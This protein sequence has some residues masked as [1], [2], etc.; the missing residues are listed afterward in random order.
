MLLLAN[1]SRNPQ[2]KW[3]SDCAKA[4]PGGGYLGFLYSMQLAGL[5]GKPPPNL[6]ASR[7]FRGT[8]IAVMNTNLLDG[9]NNIQIDFK[10]SPFGRQSH[11]YNSNNAFLL[12]INGQRAFISSGN[13]DLYGSEHHRKWMC[14][15]KS[16]NA[17]L[18][19]GKGQI[20]HA[21]AARGHISAFETSPTVDVVVGEAA[22]SYKDLQRWTRRILFFKPHAVLV[23][24]ILDAPEPATFDWLLHGMGRFTI[25][26]QEVRWEGAAGKAHIQFL[27]PDRLAVSQTDFMDPPPGDYAQLKW[28]EWH[29]SAQA[30]EKTQHREFI[31]LFTLQDA[32]VTAE[33]EKGTPAHIHLQFTD[34]TAEVSLAP[35]QFE[36]NAPGFAKTLKNVAGPA[37]VLQ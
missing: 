23:H 7:C 24:D 33:Y 2:W 6:P 22:E 34:A 4:E 37:V 21:P 12:N 36:I 26:N 30:V 15:T 16:D 3:Y 8:G 5:E 35:D 17:I 13:R 19:N 28:K 1:G 11:G 25:E 20:P 29:L 10:S 32:S 27:E 14:E 18:V 9:K 31:V